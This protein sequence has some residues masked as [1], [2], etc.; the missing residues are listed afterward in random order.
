MLS[1]DLWGWLLGGFA[2]ALLFGNVE[3]IASACL[4]LVAFI[5]V[6]IALLDFKITSI[7]T[8]AAQGGV[9]DGI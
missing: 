2:T 1:N 6:A 8:K 4:I 5:G 3:A 9:S 7:E